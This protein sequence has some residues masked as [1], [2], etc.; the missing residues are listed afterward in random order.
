MT[1]FKMNM[2]WEM[3]FNQFGVLLRGLFIEIIELSSP[4]TLLHEVETCI[5]LMSS[6][7]GPIDGISC[8]MI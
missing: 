5:L 1:W 3:V 8:S 6:I 4:L 7:D 2:K